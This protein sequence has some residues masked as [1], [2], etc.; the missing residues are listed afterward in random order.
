[1]NPVGADPRRLAIGGDS[2][3][4]NLSAVVAQATRGDAVA[5]ALQALFYPATDLTCSFPSHQRMADAFILGARA[6]A[7]EGAALAPEHRVGVVGADGLAGVQNGLPF[8]NGYIEL[9]AVQSDF[10]MGNNGIRYGFHL[11]FRRFFS[12]PFRFVNRLGRWCNYYTV[13]N[14]RFRC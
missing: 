13:T 3:G 12:R 6:I 5:P 2:A 4:G 8:V 10:R 11:F 14:F 7:G 1:M 9:Y